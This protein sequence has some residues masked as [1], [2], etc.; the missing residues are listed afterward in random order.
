MGER[1]SSGDRRVADRRR[2]QRSPVNCQIR[3]LSAAA[4][5]TIVPGRL[6]DASESGVRLLLPQSIAVGEK[7]L[8]EARRGS[9]VV[10]NVTVQVIWA[11]PAPSDQIIAGCESL[12]PLSSRQLAQLK[13]ACSE[14]AVATKAPGG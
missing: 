10:C 14:V 1:R 13:P 4:P 3:L 9:R 12:S 5:L 7:L 2:S 6:H 11:V 8:V